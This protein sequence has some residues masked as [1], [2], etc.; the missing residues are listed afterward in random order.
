MSQ[1]ISAPSQKLSPGCPADT[2]SESLHDRLAR[3]T[4]DIPKP[5]ETRE[6]AADILR[7]LFG[8]SRSDDISATNNSTLFKELLPSVPERL[9][10]HV[11]S[12][13]VT[14]STYDW[15]GNHGPVTNFLDISAKNISRDQI[16]FLAVP[17][18]AEPNGSR[19]VRN[20]DHANANRLT[21]VSSTD[22]QIISAYR[23][24]RDAVNKIIEQNFSRLSESGKI[25]A[26]NHS[27]QGSKSKTV[28][29]AKIHSKLHAE[30][31]AAL[32]LESTSEPVSLF[33][34]TSGN[35]LT[36]YASKRDSSEPYRLLEARKFSD[37]IG[38]YVAITPNILGNFLTSP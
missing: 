4:S 29:F 27:L 10:K 30:L 2:I 33:V 17:I 14:R 26:K 5:G 35:V 25:E 3:A 20:D 1:L 18:G 11:H 19:C 7:P 34:K 37:K 12:F 8:L 15:A 24:N 22:F 6:F 32:Q 9:R 23:N 31:V 13:H 28:R 38:E 21:P 36:V 16:Y